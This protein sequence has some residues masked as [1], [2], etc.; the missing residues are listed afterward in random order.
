M[1]NIDLVYEDVRNAVAAH[2]FTP[3]PER[4]ASAQVLG[5]PTVP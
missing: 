3:G 5:S 1:I 4:E 2:P